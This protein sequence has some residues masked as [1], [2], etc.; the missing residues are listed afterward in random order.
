M[1]GLIHPVDATMPARSTRLKLETLEGRKLRVTRR[2]IGTGLVHTKTHV[3]TMFTH[4]KPN[5][6]IHIIGIN[7]S[8]S[9]RCE[10][11]KKF[12]LGTRHAFNT[13]ESF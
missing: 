7:H 5:G 10:R 4:F 12:G 13:A 8:D 6:R 3:P 11:S 1:R 9:V 2:D